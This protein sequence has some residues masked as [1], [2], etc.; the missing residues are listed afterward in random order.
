MIPPLAWLK[1]MT[2]YHPRSG[3]S[4]DRRKIEDAVKIIAYIQTKSQSQARTN[5]TSC[6][7]KIIVLHAD[8]IVLRADKIVLRADKTVIP[9]QK[10][11]P[12][13]KTAKTTN[14]PHTVH[15]VR[16]IFICFV[17]LQFSVL[18]TRHSDVSDGARIRALSRP[19][20]PLPRADRSRG[21][22]RRAAGSCSC[23]RARPF[24]RGSACR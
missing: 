11:A 6:A 19:F 21:D 2:V 12:A 7:D 4:T 23:N 1:T 20:R 22:R 15:G 16:G 18:R 3:L 8:K 13:E 24:L 5:R 9:L 10:N 17:R 14:P